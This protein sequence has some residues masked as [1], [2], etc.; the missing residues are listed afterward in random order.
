M[1]VHT[2]TEGEVL[3]LFCTHWA[4]EGD[5]GQIALH[6]G[7]LATARQRTNVHH[8]HL[9]FRQLLHQQPTAIT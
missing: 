8:Q 5:L 4:V 1:L 7:H 2:P 3:P 9:P 6:S